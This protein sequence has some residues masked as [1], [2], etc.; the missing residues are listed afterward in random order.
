MKSYNHRT[1]PRRLTIPAVV[2]LTAIVLSA[3]V[4]STSAQFQEIQVLR[5]QDVGAAASA[6]I[7]GA[8][9]NQHLSGNGSPTNFDVN[10]TNVRAHAVAAG[11]VNGDGIQDVV[12][13]APDATFTLAPGGGPVQLRTGAG[14]VY[15]IFGKAGLSGAIDTGA[16]QA[17][18][19]IFGG[20]TGDKLGFSVAVGDVNGDGIAD[21][22]IG[23]PGADFPG[24]AA[25]PAAARNDTG[26][27]FVLLGVATL[28][29]PA[30][31][32]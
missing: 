9:T 14:I 31:I 30:L 28:G 19:T 18:L 16:S 17:N 6:T 12:V 5:V 21:I 13:G 24:S 29:N 23:A 4:F 26:A 8:T 2:F 7:L 1:L 3:I 11:D 22:T 32:D 25:P 15:V 27:A 20:K 10:L